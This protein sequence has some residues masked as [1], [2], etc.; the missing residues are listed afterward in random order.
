MIRDIV[1]SPMLLRTPSEPATEHSALD[2][3]VGQDLLDTLAAHADECVG[4]AANMIGQHRR[5]I[6]VANGA[7]FAFRFFRIPMFCQ[8]LTG[9]GGHFTVSAACLCSSCTKVCSSG[10]R[11]PLS[12]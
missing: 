3:S 12:G 11:V 4:M 6:V 10:R 8:F 5:I 9:F 7:P 2:A 1:R